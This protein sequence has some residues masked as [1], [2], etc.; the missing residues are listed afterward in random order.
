MGQNNEVYFVRPRG[1]HS[2]SMYLL[3]WSFLSST[4]TSNKSFLSV[5]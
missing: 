3:R 2:V 5:H 1:E 4:Q